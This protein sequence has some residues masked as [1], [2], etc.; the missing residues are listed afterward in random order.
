[1]TQDEQVTKELAECLESLGL[2]MEETNPNK[3]YRLMQK[4]GIVVH[5]IGDNDGNETSGYY[6]YKNGVFIKYIS[7][8]MKEGD[9][10]ACFQQT[11]PE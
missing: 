11:E 4:L 3:A 10:I 5:K 7:D 8:A 6:I 9:K 2:D 1:M